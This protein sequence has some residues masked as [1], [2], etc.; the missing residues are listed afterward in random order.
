MEPKY[1]V[2]LDMTSKRI[3]HSMQGRSK[4]G[5]SKLGVTSNRDRSEIEIHA[6]RVS[7]SLKINLWSS[8]FRHYGYKNIKWR[9]PG[10]TLS[11]SLRIPEKCGVEWSSSVFL[12]VSTLETLNFY[13]NCI[14]FNCL[15]AVGSKTCLFL[16][17]GRIVWNTNVRF[18][19]WEKVSKQ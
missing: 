3:R 5:P 18:K 14:L 16:I 11:T 10:V 15:L 17:L 12:H 13:R 1:Q 8:H 7:N 9:V 2:N 4:W 6:T 19:W